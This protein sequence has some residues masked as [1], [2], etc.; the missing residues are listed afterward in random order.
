M[1]NIHN[2]N[3]PLFSVTDFFSFSYVP[4]NESNILAESKRQEINITQFLLDLCGRHNEYFCVH[5]NVHREC[6]LLSLVW[7]SAFSSDFPHKQTSLLGSSSPL[8]SSGN[9]YF[10]SI[11]LGQ[12]PRSTEENRSPEDVHMAEQHYAMCSCKP[13]LR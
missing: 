4:F 1:L 2:R 8:L 5:S 7:E 9:H 3:L 13:F 6:C 12:S 11:L 10:N